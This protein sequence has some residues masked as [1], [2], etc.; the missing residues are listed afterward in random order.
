MKEKEI[1]KISRHSV[2]IIATRL[3]VAL[4]SFLIIAFLTRN[5]GPENYGIFSYV[6]SIS[7]VLFSFS[8][9]GLDA[10]LRRDL[11]YYLGKQKLGTIRQ[12]FVS[13]LFWSSIILFG[14]SLVLV[15]I[16]RFLLYSN[17]I[18][19][20]IP[21]LI[22]FTLFSFSTLSLTALRKFGS[23]AIAEI[24]NRALAIFFLFIF[25]DLAVTGAILSYI[26]AFLGSALISF[27]ILK[28]NLKNFKVKII[29]IRKLLN[30]F[31]L[32]YFGSGVVSTVFFYVNIFFLTYFSFSFGI[33]EVGY[34]ALA[35][36]IAAFLSEFLSFVSNAVEPAI[37][38]YYGRSDS[39]EVQNLFNFSTKYTLLFSFPIM[40]SIIFAS[41]VFVITFFKES[42]AN[43]IPMLSI[44]ALSII[45]FVLSKLLAPLV[46][47]KKVTKYF[48]QLNLLRL[49]LVLIFSAFLIPIFGGIGAAIS[50]VLSF[51]V[52]LIYFIKKIL[53]ETKIKIDT[54]VVS[55]EL[56]VSLIFVLLL[57]IPR[58]LIYVLIGGITLFIAYLI[59][60]Y[61]LRIIEKEELRMILGNIKLK[62]T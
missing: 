7:G 58:N 23:N 45:P 40:L 42:F 39:K 31:S 13:V 51:V 41:D 22:F 44:I 3:T 15:I 29:S 21:Y 32:S 20:S 12:V 26:L 59:I 52:G 37:L 24:S 38:E 1:E 50:Y 10:Y 14:L 35:L 49:I 57:F 30:G 9:L 8:F 46:L 17:F 54:S 11:P 34:Y 28:R 61:K 47:A 16:S 36:N 43:T 6:L 56:V 53:V 48:F 4:L 5:L 33:K 19:Y 18:L 62:R 55:K 27:F 60:L 2:Y 25:I